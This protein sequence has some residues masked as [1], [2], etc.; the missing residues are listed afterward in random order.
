MLRCIFP[1]AITPLQKTMC[2]AFGISTGVGSVI[3]M[4]H[5]VSA[6][7]DLYNHTT[8]S[9][10]SNI[11]EAYIIVMI[12]GVLAHRLI[13]D[14]KYTTECCKIVRSSAL[15]ITFYYITSIIYSK[16]CSMWDYWINCAYKKHTGEK[17]G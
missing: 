12:G 17:C 5:S 11:H 6:Y 10:N 15:F 13:N 3:V 7:Q 9:N 8:R 1:R 2:C 16:R 4:N 14:I